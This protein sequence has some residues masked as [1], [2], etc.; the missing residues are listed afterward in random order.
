MNPSTLAF[1]GHAER[2]RLLGGE[3]QDLLIYR[4]EERDFFTLLAAPN[5]SGVVRMLTDHCGELGHKT[6]GSIRVQGICV[7]KMMYF[8]LADWIAPHP[9]PERAPEPAQATALLCI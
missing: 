1:T 9:T 5:C 4:P 6:I 3:S 2:L 8:V 7:P